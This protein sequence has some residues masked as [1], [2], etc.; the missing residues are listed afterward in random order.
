MVLSGDLVIVANDGKTGSVFAFDQRTGDVRWQYEAG[1]G[2][3][4]HDVLLVERNVYAVTGEKGVVALDAKSGQIVWQRPV[5]PARYASPATD[6]KRIYVA[7]EDGVIHAFNAGSGAPVWQRTLEGTPSSS[8]VV[9]AGSVYAGVT[10]TGW[11][12]PWEMSGKGRHLL[13]RLGA[14]DGEILGTLALPAKPLGAPGVSN[15]AVILFAG[16]DLLAT[17]KQLKEVLW[18][19]AAPTHNQNPRLQLRGDLVY[20]G[21]EPRE[22]IA[23][24]IRDGSVRWKQKAEGAITTFRVDD[25][26]IWIG[27]AEKLWAYAVK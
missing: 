2:G 3:V 13:H 16:A 27:A 20:A 22:L 10:S 1:S 23:V 24:D 21:I 18:R 25:G 19:I 17:D 4:F 7:A 15:D 8:L 6:G 11:D 26:R 12:D 14:A 5:K 9:S